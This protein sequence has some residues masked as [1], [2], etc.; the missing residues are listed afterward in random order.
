MSKVEN[1]ELSN[2]YWKLQ[3]GIKVQEL[4]YPDYFN[5]P[6]VPYILDRSY[7][8]EY[9]SEPTLGKTDSCDTPLNCLLH[10]KGLF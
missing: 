2:Y 7:P 5:Q 9:L 8:T 6:Q 4:T 1:L 10:S 3:V